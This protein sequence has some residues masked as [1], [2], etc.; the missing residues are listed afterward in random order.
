[1]GRISYNIGMGLCSV[2]EK[3]HVSENEAAEIT[4]YSYRDFRRILE[5]KLFLSPKTLENIAVS[6]G[7]S[8]DYL[9]NFE[10]DSKKLVPGLE[11]NKE[12]TNKNNLYT[13]IGLLDE[14]IDLK[15]QM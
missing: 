3:N 10:P 6:L 5:G 1:M 14:Y 7:T 12:F 15:E 2:L 4:G 8:V 13:I 9:I 11:Y